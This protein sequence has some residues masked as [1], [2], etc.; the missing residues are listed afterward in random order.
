MGWLHEGIATP[1]LIPVRAPQGPEKRGNLVSGAR[2]ALGVRYGQP[3]KGKELT[4]VAHGSVCERC[5][6]CDP[7]R[8]MGGASTIVPP[9]C[10]S[11]RWRQG[12]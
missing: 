1:G 5:A 6:M 3:A 11:G 10:G 8:L 12:F 4:G 9:T 2:D 7:E